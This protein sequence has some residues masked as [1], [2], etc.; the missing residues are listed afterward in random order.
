MYVC[1]VDDLTRRVGLFSVVLGTALYVTGLQKRYLLGP[2]IGAFNAGSNATQLAVLACL[3]AAVVVG[4][5]LRSR[6]R[7]RRLRELGER[8]QSRP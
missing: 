2:V 8:L 4:L 6:S 3:V 7:A 5:A 1:G